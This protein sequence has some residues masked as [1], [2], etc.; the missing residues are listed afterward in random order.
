MSKHGL[1][2]CWLP[3]QP[4]PLSGE[5]KYGSEEYK[6]GDKPSY[7]YNY[8]DM[9]SYG[10]KSYPMPPEYSDKPYEYKYGNDY[11][12]Y[13]DKPSYDNEYKVTWGLG[14]RV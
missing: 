4:V 1:L 7:E 9:P 6:Y 13:G 12:K 8:G 2:L 11:A 5:Y 3:R 10:D 14:C